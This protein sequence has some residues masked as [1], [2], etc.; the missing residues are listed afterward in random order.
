MLQLP[1]M[2]KKKYNYKKDLPQIIS[3]LVTNRCV[4]HCRHCFN[5]F[6]A[7]PKG[8][9]GNSRKLD[10]TTDEIKQIFLNLGHIEYIYLA[11]GE[12]FIRKDFYEILQNIYECSGP[13]TIN[14]ST[15]GQIV[16]NTIT[17]VDNFLK[18]HPEVH[19]IVK[20]SIDGIAEDHDKIRDTPGAFARAI[21]TYLSLMHLKDK[22]KN[23][24]VGINTVF[25]SLN[26]DKIFG[27][28]EYFCR[29]NPVPDCMA[30]LLVRGESRDQACKYGL[31]LDIYKK[32]TE[33]YA[34]DMLKGKFE[35]D[36]K[37][38]IGTILMYDYIYKIITRNER[39]M[40][41][42]AGI[43][44]G[45]IDN[46]GMVGACEYSTPFGNLRECNYD[47]RK[48]WNSD[49]AD[50]IREEIFNRCFCTNEPQW[51]HPTILY[52]K[53]ILSRGIRLIKDVIS[54]LFSGCYL[55]LC[56]ER[57]TTYPLS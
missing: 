7:N 54:V 13:K 25:S 21:A 22:Y 23:L 32:W 41:C 56:R 24:K 57:D 19:L 30:Q 16:D 12:P 52:N 15:N 27:I 10:L 3:F 47:F 8:A 31:R 35:P 37:V 53:N 14:I 45:F 17:T 5:W 1:D 4:C 51:W 34:R 48:I 6:E 29:L 26:Q 40:N 39:Q 44:G 43:S 2:K 36:I 55:N 38:K 28:Y 46:E 11:G 49:R 9:I 20:V 18:G 33:L 42:Y 50:K